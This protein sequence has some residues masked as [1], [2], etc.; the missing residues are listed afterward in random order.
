MYGGVFM[1]IQSKNVWVDG[2]FQ[3]LQIDIEG[4]QI[5]NIRPYD[6]KPVDY[7]FSDQRIVPGFIDIHTH[8]GY[9]FDTNDAEEEGLLR[10]LK[11]VLDEGVTSICPTTITQ[12]EEVLT[13]ALKNVAKVQQ[14]DY[15]GA[16][17][18][19]I[20]FEGP[21]LDSSYKGAQPEQYC[22]VPDVAQMK[23]YV[24][25]SNHL[26]KIMTMAC[27][28]D[29]D[30]KMLSYC[31]EE[32]IVVSQGHSSAT[33]Q[34]AKDAIDHGAKSMTHV[35][36]GMTP[37]HHRNPGLVGAALRYTNTYGEIICDGR[38]VH[39]DVLHIYYEAKKDHAIMISDSLKLKGL[40]TGTKVLFGGNLV[41][42]YEDG[43]AHL[44]EAKNLA[45]STLKINEG[46]RILVEEAEVD[47]SYALDSCTINPATLLGIQDRKGSIEIGKDADIVVLGDDYSV[48]NTIQLGR[49][50]KNQ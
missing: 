8:G 17:I 47:F 29:V 46:L 38:H 24:E 50:N 45:G 13:A 36:N 15:E 5:V 23:R 31:N 48:V 4:R 33:L 22:V 32:G 14:S 16:Q 21:Y 18:V 27:E 6:D 10:W 9:G 3:P 11:A 35:F 25:A 1:R 44:V 37:L 26:I 19:G 41:E 12:S 40:P 43:S 42:L 39:P 28:H 20:H 49:I 7:D 30:Y 2:S 34:Q